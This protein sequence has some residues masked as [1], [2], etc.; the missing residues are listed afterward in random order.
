MPQLPSAAAPCN[1]RLSDCSQSDGSESDF[2]REFGEFADELVA[3]CGAVA[4]PL[5]SS[6]PGW[7]CSRKAGEVG[8]AACLLASAEFRLA[9]RNQ[10]PLLFTD[11]LACSGGWGSFADGWGCQATGDAALLAAVSGEVSCFL[12]PVDGRT[13]LKKGGLCE[14]TILAWPLAAA[15]ALQGG[16]ASAGGLAY[17]RAN[18]SDLAPVVAGLLN[19]GPIETMMGLKLQPRLCGLWVSSPGC[20]TP[21]HFDT[22]H[23]LLCQVRGQKRVWLADPTATRSL[24]IN[25]AGH[26]NPQ[27]SR[28]NLLRWMQ[29]DEAQLKAFPKAA[30][31]DWHEVILCPGQALYIP[32]LWW[33][34]VETLADASVSV[35]LPFDPEPGELQHPCGSLL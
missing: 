1:R 8:T 27:S 6:D 26:A 2:G 11:G 19:L 16:D 32:P 9:W 31:V 21:L 13:F 5:P 4:P 7:T 10:R 25:P 14:D 30:N 24:Y 23:G 12:S 18:L 29:G 20:V 34:H 15:R 17:T 3:C 22:C 33:H 35:L 28:L